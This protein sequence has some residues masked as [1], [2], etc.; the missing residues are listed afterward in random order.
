[1]TN[2]QDE[3]EVSTSEF[4]LIIPGKKSSSCTRYSKGLQSKTYTRII[5]PFKQV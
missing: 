1:M 2:Y 3:L 5:F 4:E